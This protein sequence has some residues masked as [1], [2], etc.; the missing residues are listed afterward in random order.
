[1][2]RDLL[3]EDQPASLR[4]TYA[5]IQSDYRRSAEAMG[6]RLSAGRILFA[7]ISPP[8]LALSLYRVARYL[9]AKGFRGPGW[10]VYTFNTYLT[11]ADIPPSTVIGRSCLLAHANGMIL[12]GRIGNNVS[13]YARVGVGG[14][15]GQGDIGGGPGLPVIEDGVSI[16]VNATILGVVRIGRDAQ[17]GAHTLVLQDVPAGAT[18]TGIPGVVR[19]T[20]ESTLQFGSTS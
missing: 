16:G 14:G 20:K 8:V 6:V 18:I 11:G 3:Q 13:L 12:N 2:A 4:Q 1:M 15:R 7:T 9:Y 5:D 17:V 19:A 10:L